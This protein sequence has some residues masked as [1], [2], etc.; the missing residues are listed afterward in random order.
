MPQQLPSLRVLLSVVLITVGLLAS[1][2]PM[3]LPLAVAGNAAQAPTPTSILASNSLPITGAVPEPADPNAAS[4]A[5]GIALN[6]VPLY[7]GIYR[8]GSWVPIRVTADNEGA[9][10]AAM[11]QVNTNRGTVFAANLDLPR[12]ARKTVLVYAFIS[13]LNRRMTVRLMDGERQLAQKNVALEPHAGNEQMVGV[14]SDDGVGI[15][16]PDRLTTNA[17]LVGVPIGL[18]DLPEHALGLSSFDALIFNDVATAPLNEAQRSALQEWVLRGGQVIVGGGATAARTLDG[19]PQAL[20]PVRVTGTQQVPAAT[21]LSSA[22]GWREQLILAQ[23]EPTGGTEATA[24]SYVRANS[25]LKQSD[26][27]QVVLERRLGR[28]SAVFVAFALNTP[29]LTS[30]PDGQ[31]FWTEL[32]PSRQVLPQDFAPNEMSADAFIESNVASVLTGL[33]ALEFPSLLLLGGLLLAYIVLVG[34]V[35]YVI[36]RRLDRQALGWIVVP[37]I[38]LTFA[39]VAYGLG[40]AQ[41]GGDVVFNQITLVEPLNPDEGTAAQARVRSFVGLFSPSQE[42][43]TINAQPTNSAESMPL[44][45]PI[46]IQGPWDPNTNTQTGVFLQDHLV[47]NGGSA[48]VTNLDV[49]QWSMRAM[50]ADEV[51]PYRGLAAQLVFEG[52]RL[53]AEVVNN[54]DQPV[55]DV[56]LVQGNRIARLGTLAPGEQR[57]VLMLPLDAM[58]NAKFGGSVPPLSYLMYGEQLDK[59]NTPGGV[60]LAAD[61]QLRVRL[62]DSLYAYGPIQ[63]GPQPLLIAWDQETPL[64][65]SIPGKRA[66][67]QDL[68]LIT[69]S[70]DLKVTGKTVELEQGWLERRFDVWPNGMCIGSQGPGVSMLDQ[71]VIGTLHLPRNFVGIEATELT[72]L[73]FADGVWP[74]ELRIDLFD[75]ERSEWVAQD[76]SQRRLL[77]DEPARFVSS[78]GQVRVRLEGP[79]SPMNNAGCLSVDATIKGSL[80]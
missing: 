37:V 25:A 27:A 23:T 30:W 56:T 47:G 51:R 61:I 57:N 45:R 35:T 74:P 75:W 59:A 28:G 43:Y 44:M 13:N 36:L 78:N 11:V 54:G 39:V 18:N 3:A 53:R 5:T 41:R 20:Q 60:P 80:P 32:L 76:A 33:P 69:F 17:R 14:I 22:E 66:A 10:L 50:L 70:P 26:E 63:R 48:Q 77:I 46:S 19:L 2:S 67:R 65:M 15:R 42:R 31:R 6:A 73:T 38:T 1:A 71:T 24:Q 21:L 12:G 58:L 7:D 49:A 29:V 64:Q 40:Y 79:V 16:L 52:T 8:A 34:P 68:T 72:L 62:L 4:D 55:R 9:D